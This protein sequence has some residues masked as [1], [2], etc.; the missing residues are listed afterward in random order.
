MHLAAL[1][2]RTY[3]YPDFN[4]KGH[5]MGK[6]KDHS[7]DAPLA[8]LIVARALRRR[9]WNVKLRHAPA[10]YGVLTK[11]VCSVAGAALGWALPGLV[12]SSRIEPEKYRG[13]AT[14]LAG[15]AAHWEGALDA[16]SSKHG[17][18][19]QEPTVVETSFVPDS[20]PSGGNA[21]QAAA[22]TDFPRPF[23]GFLCSRCGGSQAFAPAGMQGGV[24]VEEAQTIGWKYMGHASWICPKCAPEVEGEP[25]SGPG[26]GAEDAAPDEPNEAGL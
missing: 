22:H 4:R 1:D 23:F 26:T 8:E 9:G 11:A 21:P 18:E 17:C 25:E 13:L 24:T 15:M 16:R 20:E 19:E 5:P 3:Q 10:R 7:A 12:G 2:S 6:H 14:M